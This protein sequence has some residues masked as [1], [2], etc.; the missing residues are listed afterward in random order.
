MMCPTFATERRD[1]ED[2]MDD[3]ALRRQLTG[4]LDGVGAHMP[5]D[6]A[7]ADFPDDA[8]NRRP[9]NV[10]Y[11]PWHLLEHLRLTQADILDY[12]VNEAYVE[13]SWPADFWPE[14]DTTATREMFDQTIRAF[15]ADLVALRALVADPARDLF[16]IIRGTPGH[17]LLREVRIDAD[18]NAYHVGEFAILRQVMGTWPPGDA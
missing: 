7:V 6:E 13:P 11:T 18:H 4:L 1:P 9:P 3:D 2:V 5:F 12:V 17:T 14:R 15:R 8:I 16:A 10:D